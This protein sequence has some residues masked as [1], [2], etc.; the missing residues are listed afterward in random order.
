MIEAYVVLHRQGYA[1]SFE[2]Y[3][4]TELVGGLY[5]V[6]TWTRAVWG[7]DG[8]LVPD[9]SKAALSSLCQESELHQIDLIDCQVPTSHLE[10][11]GASL[12]TRAEFIE[13]INE[14]AS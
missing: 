13:R 1:I 4:G 6:R 2:T 10:S 11:L 8:L 7:I 5:G 14:L 12:I 3:R 9:A